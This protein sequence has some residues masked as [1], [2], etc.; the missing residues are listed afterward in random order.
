MSPFSKGETGLGCWHLHPPSP[1][2]H[3]SSAPR[4]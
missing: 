3:V 4:T 1:P 2:S